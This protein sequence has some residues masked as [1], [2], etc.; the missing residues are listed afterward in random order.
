M[1]GAEL[2]AADALLQVLVI[3]I[4]RHYLVIILR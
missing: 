3:M 4:F 1:F 2:A